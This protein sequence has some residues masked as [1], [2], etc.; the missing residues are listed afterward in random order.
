[1][2]SPRGHHPSAARRAPALLAALGTVLATS[3]AALPAQAITSVESDEGITWEIHD[4]APPSLDTGSIRTA[5]DSPIQ[6][7]GNIFVEVEAPE[8]VAEPRL[9]GEMVRGFGLTF[10]G[11]A[12]YE[13]T[14][15]VDFAG[16]LVTRGVD[17]ETSGSSIRF[18][19]SLT[20]T[21]SEPITVSVSFGGSLGYGEGETQ[22]LVKS[23]TSG[24][25]RIGTDDS[26]ALVA[27]PDEDTRPVGIAFGEVDR[28]GNQQRDPFETPLAVEGG[29]A[30]FYGFVNEIE[31][32]P[33]TTASF[34]RFVTLGE[35]GSERL[36]TAAQSVAELA[37]APDLAGLTVPEVCT[38]VNWDISAL[39]GY[40]AA[41]C[42]DVTA[43]PTPA[44]PDAPAPVT[45][46]AYDVVGKTI[47]ELKADM[48]A[49]VVTSE[50]ITQAY[51][52]RIAVYDGGPQG[53]HAFITVADDALEQARAA[54]E[55]RAAGEDG[56]LLGIPIAVKDLY[57][58]FDMPT[59]GGSRALE[60]FQPEQDAFQVAQLRE[61]GA[62][63]IGKANT[64][65]FAFSGGFSESGWMQTWN[66]LYPSK[67]SFGS[68]GGSA[69][70]VA[71]SMAAGAM[72]TQTGVSLYAPT[73]GASLTMF[74]GTDGM[75]SGTGVIPLTWYQDYAGPIA[76]T[77]TDLAT[78]LNATT[79]TDPLDPLTA[80]ADEHR[81][82]DWSDSL[83]ASAL[84]GMR[85]GYLPD[86]FD[87][88]YATNGT[89]EFLETQLS[90][91]EDAGA[92]VVQ[93]SDPP[94][95]GRSPSGSRGMEGWARYIE[96]HENFPYENGNE[97]Y[98]SDAVLPYNQRSLGDTPRLTEEEVEAWVEYRD[99]YKELIAEWMDEY[100]VDAV[101]YPGF[102]SD[103][104]NNDAQTSRLTSDR[105]TGVLTS[106]VGLP[107]VVVPAG[108]NPNGY[109]T[110][111]QIVGRAWDDAT[112]LGM[113]YA[114]EQEIQGQQHTTFAPAL[115]YVGESTS[116]FVDVSV[117]DMFFTEIAWLA[118]EGISTGWS[119]PQGQEYRPL[120]PIARDAMAAFLYRMA[121]VED[122]TPPTTSPFTDVDTSDQFYTEIAWLAEQ[123]IST[124]WSTPQ[125]QEYRPLEPIARDAMAAF[126]YRMAE[127]EDYTAPT[128]SPFTDVATSNQ[129]YTEIAW[130]QTSGI[131]TGWEGNNG[132]SLYQP[133]T[134]VA[135]D[136]MAAFLYR[137]DHLED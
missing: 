8:G 79:G 125:G 132:T 10:D 31:I 114:L 4:A 72:G 45:S 24:D 48:A 67:T 28:M 124:G 102:I 23:T 12:S 25:A 126:L 50:E 131:S 110:S 80:E 60:G 14:Q 87:S 38:I 119:T 89:G 17:V 54:D 49:G 74:R 65:E 84:E 70:S 16:V 109:S 128:T 85:L 69:V 117:E 103:M 73:T 20:N 91:F 53:F 47:E 100:D 64:S 95:N 11:D 37:A 136:A 21:T 51:L 77:V 93:M 34:A 137:Y 101:V 97:V 68:S 92:N 26:W 2:R 75:S 30:S 130:M 122:Y 116:P 29:E 120:Q 7:F 82:E 88:N 86:S 62:I 108:T 113:G 63:I 15:S 115:T 121:E 133:L 76:R 99:G 44:A 135:R 18:L 59:T 107:T 35:T 6:G 9:N 98:A 55:A 127:V 40:D 52:D 111:L 78:M 27:T 3:L 66:A 123:G 33:G 81:P 42:E 58:T 13:S 105:S 90:M 96:L 22:G 39:P 32:E 46:V 106:S 129:F 104:Y 19:D 61:A 43:L 118:E 83:D 112:V 134:D 71:T 1:M 36:E 56:E 5:S 94:S 57:D 41:V